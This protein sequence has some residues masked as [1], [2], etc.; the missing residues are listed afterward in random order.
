[1]L[2]IKHAMSYSLGKEWLLPPKPQG[3][4][5]PCQDPSP[6]LAEEE[7][8]GLKEGQPTPTLSM[9]PYCYPRQRAA[10]VVGKA[11]GGGAGRALG[12]R[13]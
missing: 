7:G 13:R 1:M 4:G 2:P 10:V 9:P 12:G 8:Q 5:P 11:Q 3:G 6:P